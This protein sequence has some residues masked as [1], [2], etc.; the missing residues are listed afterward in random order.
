M[1]KRNPDACLTPHPCLC[2][3]HVLVCA[4]SIRRS[5]P[6]SGPT[7]LAGGCARLEAYGTV[8]GCKEGQLHEPVS[9]NPTVFF[10]RIAKAAYFDSVRL[11]E[12]EPK[13]LGQK[14]ADC[15]SHA[16]GKRGAW[17]TEL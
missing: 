16:F 4:E 12:S 8:Y 15:A 11:Y 17:C 7:E 6:T 2:S 14:L 9:I 10:Q 3:Y 13:T 1:L 5:D